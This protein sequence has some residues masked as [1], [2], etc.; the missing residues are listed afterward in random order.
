MGSIEKLELIL[1]PESQSDFVTRIEVEALRTGPDRIMVRYLVHGYI[2][3]LDLP[4]EM[5]TGRADDLWQRT[6]FEAFI[7]VPGDPGYIELNFSPS[8]KWAAYRFDAYRAEMRSAPNVL[9]PQYDIR[10]D[11]QSYDFLAF[12]ELALGDAPVWSAGL[13]AVIEEK[14]GNKSFWALSHPPGAPDFHHQ[15]CFATELRAAG[16]T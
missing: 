2:D 13:S 1:H 3:M 8:T 4:S 7:R 12:V 11:E 14:S 5:P 16:Q 6:C 15:D 10:R 9:Q